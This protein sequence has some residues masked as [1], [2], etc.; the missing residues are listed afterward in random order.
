MKTAKEIL[1]QLLEDIPLPPDGAHGEA[2]CCG[3]S[4]I[5][6]GHP[7]GGLVLWAYGPVS[8][9]VVAQ[10]FAQ[11]LYESLPV[12]LQDEIERHD[13]EELELRL[14]AWTRQ[15]RRRAGGHQTR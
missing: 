1:T 8:A 3:E 2:H 12:P 14:M 9:Y 13:G 10:G 7:M 6:T 5:E 15:E 4:D 11:A